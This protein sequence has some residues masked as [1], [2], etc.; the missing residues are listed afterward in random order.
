LH[1]RTFDGSTLEGVLAEVHATLGHDARIVSAERRR[2]GGLGGFFA[3]ERFEVVVEVP[4]AAPAPAPAPVGGVDAL[5][6]LADAVSAGERAADG[7]ARPAVRP[8]ADPV[9]A[10]AEPAFGA[11][12]ARAVALAAEPAPVPGPI[13]HPAFADV[14]RLRR[15]EL[16]AAPPPAPVPA[17]EP[18]PAPAPVSVLAAAPPLSARTRGVVVVAGP[19]DA[20]RAV[21]AR[22]A[23]ELAGGPEQVLVAQPEPPAGV[24]AWMW[25]RDVAD[26]AAREQAW[27]RRRVPVIVALPLPT[28]E[29]EDVTWAAAMAATL[30][31]VA[32]HLVDE[33]A[34]PLGRPVAALDGG[35][36]SAAVWAALFERRPAGVAA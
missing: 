36:T 13:T 8:A 4:D 12:F 25:L 16:D 26:A 17:H 14:P 33:A 32:L 10:P 21:A 6:Q 7:S 29:Q 11:L 19:A 5:L 30:R 2:S 34:T 27:A 1:T 23:G 9:V 18:A 28:G 24:P 3:K 22:L 20:A 31:P 35:P 15:A